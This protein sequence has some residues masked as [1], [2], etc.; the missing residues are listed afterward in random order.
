MSESPPMQLHSLDGSTG[1]G[2]RWASVM[3]RREFVNPCPPPPLVPKKTR[4]ASL[5]ERIY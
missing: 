1:W 2:A 3:G 4:L 5:V